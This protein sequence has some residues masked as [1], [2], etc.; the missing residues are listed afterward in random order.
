M[1]VTT[2]ALPLWLF[3]ELFIEVT[4]MAPQICVTPLRPGGT[5]CCWMVVLGDLAGPR[6]FVLELQEPTYCTT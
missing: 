5:N 2:L 1:E 4:L 6:N 3:N